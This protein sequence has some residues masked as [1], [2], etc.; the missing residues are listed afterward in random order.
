MAHEAFY[1]AL[2]AC[3]TLAAIHS[4]TPRHA[5]PITQAAFCEGPQCILSPAETRSVGTKIGKPTHSPSPRILPLPVRQAFDDHTSKRDTSSEQCKQ[6]NMNS[7]SDT[8]WPHFHLAV[9][10]YWLLLDCMQAKN[11]YY[12]SQEPIH[13][14]DLDI[15]HQFVAS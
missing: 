2:K 13:E 8:H 14:I 9:Y 6:Y 7:L 1:N 15:I 5:H 11:S 12:A 3:H 10:G 4:D